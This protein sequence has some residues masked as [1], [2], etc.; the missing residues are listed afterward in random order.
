[1]KAT[2]DPEPLPSEVERLEGRAE[3]RNLVGIYAALSDRT[4]DD[5]LAEIGSRGFGAFKPAMA[6]L[7]VAVLAPMSG[8]MQRMVAGHGEMDRILRDGADRARALAE[9]VM[10]DVRRIVGFVR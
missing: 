2:T 7:A 5:V 3:A 10:A 8:E 1:R 6:D 4:R 9:P